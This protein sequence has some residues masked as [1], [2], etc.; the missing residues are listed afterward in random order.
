MTT[1]SSLCLLPAC[2]AGACV[3]LA[4]TCCPYIPCGS[5][6]ESSAEKVARLIRDLGSDN[7]ETREAASSELKKMEEA[8]PA[9]RK[10]AAA[11]DAEVQRRTAEILE[12]FAEKRL[13]R[14]LQKATALV[15]EGRIDQAV[16][17][18]VLMKKSDDEEPYWDPLMRFAARLD[19]AERRAFGKITVLKTHPLYR[20]RPVGEFRG[21]PKDFPLKVLHFPKAGL[22]DT[23]SRLIRGENV[24]VEGDTAYCLVAASGAVSAVNLSFS[25]VFSNGDVK[26]DK[27]HSSIIVCDGNVEARTVIGNSLVIA[28]GKVTL[29]RTTGGSVVMALQVKSPANAE[30]GSSSIDTGNSNP[31]GVVKFF[32]PKEVGLVVT[33]R[34]YDSEK[35]L[36]P[37]GLLVTEVAKDKPF[38]SAI[39][40]GDVIHAIDGLKAST[41]EDFRKLLRKRLAQEELTITFTVERSGTTLEVPVRMRE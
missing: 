8:V 34:P 12:G 24:S 26:V 32:D 21:Y 14:A 22:T 3:C 41:P 15:K 10:A 38:A 23:L 9:L 35:R 17:R 4:L 39:R 5:A 29:P 31:L 13:A 36:V 20:L 40:W 30:I 7:Y 27:L 16:E 25:V 19:E 11:G 18:L 28:R 1:S 37:E 2:L 6:A 33:R